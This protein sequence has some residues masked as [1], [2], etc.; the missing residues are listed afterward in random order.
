MIDQFCFSS[1]MKICALKLKETSNITG[2]QKLGARSRACTYHAPKT[3]LW[4]T[5]KCAPQ[6]NSD[7]CF[8]K[9]L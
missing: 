4:Y 9:I 5:K 3:S 1:K 8:T 7:I 2:L 6:I